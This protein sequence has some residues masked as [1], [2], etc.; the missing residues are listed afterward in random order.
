MTAEL[1]FDAQETCLRPKVG[2]T[3][4]AK[5]LELHLRTEI[6]D[7]TVTVGFFNGVYPGFGDSVRKLIK[8]LIS[9]HAFI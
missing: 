8:L 5:H 6:D 2:C 4:K 9:G 1:A 3:V 7:Q